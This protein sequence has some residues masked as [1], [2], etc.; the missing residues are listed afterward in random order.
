M[1]GHYQESRHARRAGLTLGQLA[2]P[3]WSECGIDAGP[4]SELRK[5]PVHFAMFWCCASPVAVPCVC[6]P[7][8]RLG[9]R[10]DIFTPVSQTVTKIAPK[11]DGTET[12]RKSPALAIII[13]SDG[14]PRLCLNTSSSV[15]WYLLALGN[16]TEIW[17]SLSEKFK[18]IMA[19]SSGWLGV[20]A[21]R[22]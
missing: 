17:N 8:A 2:T 18:T 10:Q 4:P 19:I 14:S 7:E 20:A 22:L 11:F 9:G 13:S 16:G 5:G 21:A 1:I 6:L 3:I 12:V 15:S